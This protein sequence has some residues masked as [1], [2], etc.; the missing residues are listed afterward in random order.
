MRLRLDKEGWEHVVMITPTQLFR[1]YTKDLV[2][3][4]RLT[5]IENCS[6][7]EFYKTLITNYSKR[8]IRKES[9]GKRFTFGAKGNMQQM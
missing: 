2:K 3:K 5:Q 9:K 6:I 7:V 1:E 8:I 4:Y